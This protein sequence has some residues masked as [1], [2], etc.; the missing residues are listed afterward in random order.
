LSFA[1]EQGFLP[2]GA[3]TWQFNFKFDLKSD[4]HAKDAI[5]LLSNSGINFTKHYSHG[6]NPQI[7]AEYLISSGLVLNEEVKW[8]SFHGGFDFAYLIRMLTGLALPEDDSSFYNILNTY[9]PSFY[10]IK[11][12]T[13]ELENLK[14]GG[15]S[16]LASDLSV[17]RIGPQHQAGSDS[18]L[19]L[20]TFFKLRDQYFKNTA[21]TK[22]SNM[23]YGIGGSGEEFNDYLQNFIN[24]ENYPMMFNGYH[25]NNLGSLMNGG[26]YY[27]QADALFNNNPNNHYNMLHFNMVY[28][29]FAPGPYIDQNNQKGKK[30]DQFIGKSDN[31]KG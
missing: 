4:E 22:L 13:K 21:E 25:V 20:S 29:N 23:L 18:L 10:D 1:D 17:K 6:I 15:L 8:I 3:S 26:S 31:R 12:L 24:I 2:A 7:F 28:N 19:T 11:Y 30:Y 9:F 5:E 14:G 16:K 27:S